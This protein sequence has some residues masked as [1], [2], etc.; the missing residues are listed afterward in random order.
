MITLVENVAF[1][2]YRYMF[3]LAFIGKAASLLFF[4][5]AWWCYVPPGSRRINPEPEP[6][7]VATLMTAADVPITQQNSNQSNS[8]NF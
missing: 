6:E 2:F 5:L 1:L 7:P 8:L 3:G 4:F